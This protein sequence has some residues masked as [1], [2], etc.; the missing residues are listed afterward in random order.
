MDLD[1]DFLEIE[2]K[3]PSYGGGAFESNDSNRHTTVGGAE[4][5]VGRAV[6]EFMKSPRCYRRNPHQSVAP[7]GLPAL[8]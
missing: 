2:K 7:G 6:D 4:D 5:E 8:N 3:K 1:D